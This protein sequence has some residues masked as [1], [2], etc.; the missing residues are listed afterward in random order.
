[1]SIGKDSVIVSSGYGR[2]FKSLIPPEII[3]A[4]PYYAT[5]KDLTLYPSPCKNDFYFNVSKAYN[6]QQVVLYNSL[7]QKKNVS[8]KQRG[9]EEYNVLLPSGEKG[10]Y[11][12]EVMCE[13]NKV[14]RSKLVIE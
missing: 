5:K 6:P 7:G 4:T 14:L 8:F 10:L 12:V 11:I 3:S 9:L 2:I 1:M 13:N